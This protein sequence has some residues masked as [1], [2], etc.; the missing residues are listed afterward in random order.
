MDTLLI[1][2]DYNNELLQKKLIR[3]YR[4]LA[5]IF[6]ILFLICLITFIPIVI[7]KKPFNFRSKCSSPS[8]QSPSIKTQKYSKRIQFHI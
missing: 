4:L 1:D 6:G 7:H 8:N 2:D 5:F 3:K